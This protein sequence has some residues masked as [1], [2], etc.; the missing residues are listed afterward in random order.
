MLNRILGI[1][2]GYAAMFILTM[3]LFV[4]LAAVAPDSF[5]DPNIFPEMKYIIVILFATFVS[6]LIGGLVMSLIVKPNPMPGAVG[7]SILILILGIISAV[8]A[9]PAQ[10]LWYHAA[11][12]ILAIAGVMLIA[13][14]RKPKTA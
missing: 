1:I 6:A 4:V 5:A 3:T 11:L 12:I 13:L 14:L 10:P 9:P 7:M 2:A 8:A